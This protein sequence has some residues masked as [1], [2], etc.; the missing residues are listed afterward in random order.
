M[1]VKSNIA[2][3][4]GDIVGSSMLNAEERSLFL[5]K[6]KSFNAE[7]IL[8]GPEFYRGDS[9][10]LA[11][12]LQ[13]SL[14]IALKIRAEIKCINDMNDVRISIGIGKISDWKENILLATGSAFERSGKNLDRLKKMGLNLLVI[15]GNR[16]L[17]DELETYCELIDPY[18][19]NLSAN[20][21]N[22]VRLKIEG[23]IKRQ[24]EQ[25]E[26]GNKTELTTTHKKATTATTHANTTNTTQSDISA[27][28]NISQPAVSKSL[29]AANWKVIERFIKRYEQIID[30]NYGTSE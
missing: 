2:V 21:A 9:F 29:K 20:Q 26:R 6:V 11:T 23:V 5:E 14:L 25:K 13:Y 28:L 1:V 24:L 17:D 30:K 16:E 7:N 19:K 4:T 27:Q 22:I 12:Y 10:Q 8:L 15:T 18:L 3:V